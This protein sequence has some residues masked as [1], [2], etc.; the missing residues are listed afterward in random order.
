MPTAGTY[1]IDNSPYLSSSQ[2]ANFGHNLS[3]KKVKYV[4]SN[5]C[6]TDVI[7]KKQISSTM[8]SLQSTAR[9]NQSVRLRA[10]QMDL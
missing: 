6:I 5:A 8:I 3:V 9:L 4:L 2:G 7:L 1:S 10:E